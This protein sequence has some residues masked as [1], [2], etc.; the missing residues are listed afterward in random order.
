MADDFTFLSQALTFT[1]APVMDGFKATERIRQMER[2]IGNL[3]EEQ[4]HIPILALTASAT[5]DYRQKCFRAGMDDFLAKVRCIST[6]LSSVVLILLPRQ[7][8]NKAALEEM[9]HKWLGNPAGTE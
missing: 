6:A 4:P 8:L 1:S 5:A 9:L 3:Q 7:P 2:Q